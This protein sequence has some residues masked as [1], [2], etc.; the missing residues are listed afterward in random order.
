MK[1]LDSVKKRLAIRL[2]S[3]GVTELKVAGVS[4]V[5]ET[6]EGDLR[7]LPTFG[8]FVGPTAGELARLF[9]P[10]PD[11]PISADTNQQATCFASLL[12]RGSSL[13]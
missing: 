12:N 2:K 5:M 1:V 6:T 7:P 8:E 13:E 11:N 10:M 9:D 4:Q 3:V